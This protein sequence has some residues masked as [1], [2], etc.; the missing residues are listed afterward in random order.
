MHAIASVLVA[1]LA[2]LQLQLPA[3]TGLVNDF[4]GVLSAETRTRLEQLS[5]QVRDKSAGEIAVVTLPD[6]AGR[7]VEEVSLRI[8]REWGVG[9]KAAVGDRTRNAGTVVLVIP[10]ETSGD[11]RG[12]CRIETGQGVEGFLTDAEAGT[13][14]R[15]ATPLFQ[16]R[17]Y[18]GATSL[19]V[20]RV[21][22]KYA[23]SFGFTLDQTTAAPPP[24]EEYQPTTR[25]RRGGIDPF[26]ALVVFFVLVSV[27]GSMG[28]RRRGCGGCIPIF[29]PFGG[30][31]G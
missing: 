9:A 29:I 27:L 12:H 26:V 2:L 13:I 5:Q 6:L 22:E 15:E 21:A 8:L 16:Q 1:L 20:T 31:G 17:D 10:K 7:P 28:R 18:D 23:A 24:A 4:A 25:R 14:C 11:G 19:L 3:P 30:G